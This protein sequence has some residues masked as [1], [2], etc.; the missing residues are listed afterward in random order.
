MPITV[1]TL[2]ALGACDEA[3]ER[4]RTVA[5]DGAPDWETIAESPHCDPAWRG[6]IAAYAPGLPADAR[7][8][9]AAASG[10]PA[11]WM[12]AVAVHA[13]NLSAAQREE[14]ADCSDQPDF[15]CGEAALNAPGLDL[16]ERAALARRCRYVSTLLANVAELGA[17][18][19]RSIAVALLRELG[20]Q[21]S[22]ES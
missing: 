3:L 2:A 15:W 17:E 9:Y 10:R 1:E 11:F 14:L 22:G 7:R 19:E 21:P 5:P 18:R 20:A 4:F 16:A 12:G 13:D 6:W 8:R